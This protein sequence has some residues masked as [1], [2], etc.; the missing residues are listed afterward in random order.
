MKASKADPSKPRIVKLVPGPEL[1]DLLAHEGDLGY[2]LLY[3][4]ETGVIYAG[5]DELA[6]WRA[7]LQHTSGAKQ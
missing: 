7:G 6:A 2:P 3:R 5:P 1:D 4:D